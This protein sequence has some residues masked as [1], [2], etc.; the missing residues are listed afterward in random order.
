MKKRD[1][2]KAKKQI[3]WG[4]VT[5]VNKRSVAIYVVLRF[6]V[7]ALMIVQLIRGN[8]DNVFL[9]L[10][11]LVLF[12]IPAILD[13]GFN[14][15]LPT[16]LEIVIIVFIFSAEILGEMQNFYSHFK[17]WD[18]ILHTVNGFLMAAIGF[19]MV[20]ILNQSPRI[21][22]TMSPVFVAFVAF[23]FSMTIGIIWE[24]FEFSMDRF[25]LYDMQK[26][27]IVQNFASSILNPEH[28]N[29]PVVLENIS[30]TVIYYA[31]DGKNLTETVNGGYVDIGIIDTMKDL[32]VNFIGAAVFSTIGAFYVKS[33][34][35][36][37]V[38]QSFIPYFGDGESAANVKDLK[39]NYTEGNGETGLFEGSLA[40][41]DKNE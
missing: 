3:K 24:F 7:T 33:R 11:T 17:N 21:H 1:K 37:K 23:C 19:A 29:K 18:T 28:L 32:F 2:T 40:S 31:K 26:D 39:K 12:F 15:K 30:K 38:A 9:C 20:D 5:A 6:L 36:S 34:G 35:K 8:Y 4:K 13:R 41:K 10:L 16:A 25:F 22:L 27:F 14:I